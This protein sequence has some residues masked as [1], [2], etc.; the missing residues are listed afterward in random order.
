MSGEAIL[1]K[2]NDAMPFGLTTTSGITPMDFLFQIE[3]G[4]ISIYASV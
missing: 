1:A 2:E 3:I 4:S